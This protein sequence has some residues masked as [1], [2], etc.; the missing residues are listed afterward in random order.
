MTAVRGRAA[1][2]R[3]PVH[4]IVRE[5]EGLKRVVTVSGRLTGMALQGAD[6]DAIV[7]TLADSTSGTVVVL[8]PMLQTLAAAGPDDAEVDTSWMGGE[9][10]LA[11]MLGAV[12]H[13][14]Q[15]MRIPHATDPGRP[16]FAVA[17]ILVGE[18]VLAYL[19]AIAAPHA[20][21]GDFDLLV[22]E[23]AASISAIVMSRGRAM[24][25][26]GGRVRDDL[27]DALLLGHARSD[28]ESEEWARALGYD[29]DRRYRVMALTPED[30]TVVTGEEDPKGPATMALRRRLLQSLVQLVG[31]RSADAIPSARQ[32]EVVVLLPERRER[33]R[34]VTATSL[35]DAA[36]RHVERLMGG[37]R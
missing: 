2:A 32:D 8:D 18:D 25:E 14:R 35:G 17:P 23:H 16:G 34:A 3:R 29:L 5:N 30:L 26:V 22:T 15:A 24:A 9:P 28:R 4:E 31:A 1:P 19:L 20:A 11:E 33:E 21:S 37:A 6:L 7:A 13:S 27:V 12:A 36:I 10:Q